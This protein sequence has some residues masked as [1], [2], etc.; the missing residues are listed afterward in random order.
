[1]SALIILVITFIP[2]IFSYLY[3]RKQKT[4]CQKYPFFRLRDQVIWKMVTSE[5]VTELQD[6][7]QTANCV[8]RKLD[9]LNFGL[10]FFISAMTDHLHKLI[11]D[12]YKEALGVPV[13]HCSLK[14]NEFDKELLSLIIYAAKRNSL[15]LR[16]AMT[17]VGYRLLYF[18]A[19][20]LFFKRHPNLLKGARPQIKMVQKYSFLAHCL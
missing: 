7:Y 9:Q 16:F 6:Q 17:S 13:Q 4:I 3:F 1:M 11:D 14:L 2:I 18:R 10:Q 5:N 20:Y 19:I 15:L 8:A 12:K